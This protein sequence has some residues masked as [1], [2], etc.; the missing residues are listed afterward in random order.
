MQSHM[1]HL[2]ENKLKDAINIQLDD[3]NPS[4]MNIVQEEGQKDSFCQTLS[5][6]C[7]CVIGRK[8]LFWIFE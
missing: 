4:F 5:P 1:R 2:I 8:T 7:I 3:I 6:P